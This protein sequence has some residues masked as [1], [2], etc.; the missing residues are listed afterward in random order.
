VVAEQHLPE[1]DGSLTVV[2]I[3]WAEQLP[4]ADRARLL[5]AL[6]VESASGMELIAA[7]APVPRWAS[8][9]SDRPVALVDRP[10]LLA[11]TSRSG[12]QPP[13]RLAV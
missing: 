1:G 6:A 3:T 4:G 5:Q 8:T 12:W 9:L 11:A 13:A 2:P 7:G 10:E